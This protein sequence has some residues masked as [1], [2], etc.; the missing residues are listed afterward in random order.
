MTSAEGSA[1]GE[2]SEESERELGIVALGA[3]D[4]MGLKM[5]STRKRTGPSRRI[6]KRRL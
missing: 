5:R 2:G 3:N 4:P 6:R 1:E